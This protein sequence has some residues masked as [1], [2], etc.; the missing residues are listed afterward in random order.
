MPGSQESVATQQEKTMCDQVACLFG[1]CKDVGDGV[2]DTRLLSRS[3][4]S[5]GNM[6]IVKLAKCLF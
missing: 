2:G 5:S 6:Q 1:R 3:H 4:P